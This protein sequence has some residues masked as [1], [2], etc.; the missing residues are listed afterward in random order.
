VSESHHRARRR[1]GQNF[2][3]DPAVIERIA[4]AVSPAPGDALVEIGPGL[5]ALTRALLD[6]GADLDVIEIDRD[7]A[8]RLARTFS[9]D[10]ALRI[11]NTDALA[12]DFGALAARR[13]LLRLVGNLPYNISTPLLFRFIAH[14]ESVRDMH[15]MLQKEV[16]ER[17][18][19][20]PGGKTYGRLSVMVQFHCH[21]SP[22]FDVGAGAFSPAPRVRS[23]VVRLVPRR[24][25]PAP[26]RDR[27]CLER[28][29]TLAF[30]QRRK[31]LR[32]SLKPCL[33]DSAIG[34]AGIDPGSRPETLTLGEFA[35]LAN[36][37]AARDV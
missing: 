15:L 2:L 4:R 18:N 29:V 33:T 20:A 28:V 9:G 30:G 31:T 35:A 16:A 32:N 14:A 7:L 22:L 5:G 27:R 21:V 37:L 3:H 10:A 23:A 11:H 13:G 34:D 25:P 36:A 6:A 12:F 1:F 19:A 26:L 24:E 8:A 17:I